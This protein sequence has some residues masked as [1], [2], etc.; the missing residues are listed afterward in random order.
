ME[1]APG[2]EVTENIIAV[3]VVKQWKF[4]LGESFCA[5]EHIV[6]SKMRKIKKSEIQ[7]V[8]HGGVKRDQMG[9]S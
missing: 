3:E 5:A 7:K 6:L 9:S 8:L 2:G 1:G 4:N